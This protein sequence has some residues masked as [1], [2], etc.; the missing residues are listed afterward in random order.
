MNRGPM[1]REKLRSPT[2]LVA[3]ALVVALPAAAEIYTVSLTNGA[4]IESR[5]PPR[6]HPRDEGK[7]SMLTEVGNWISLPKEM[8]ADVTS[9]TESKGFGLVIDTQTILIGW[10]PNDAP[11]GP[12]EAEMDPTTRL[13]NYLRARDSA[14]QQDFSVQQ[15]VN[16]EDA[17]LG[18][19]PAAGAAYS[20]NT[21]FPV[22]VGGRASVEPSVIDQ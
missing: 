20:G 10:A 8:V 3:L 5:Y 4:V 15:F 12:V 19:L 7:L 18:G 2:V 1:L 13:L 22:S 6:Q 9:E 16:A 17:G 11:T 21:D 14:P